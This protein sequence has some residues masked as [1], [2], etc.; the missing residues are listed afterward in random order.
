MTR[1]EIPILCPPREL[2]TASEDAFDALAAPHLEGTAPGLVIDLS[3]V[4][5]ITSAGL[6]R[7]VSLGQ[8]M[9]ARGA[10]VALA[11]GRQSVVKLIRTVGLDSVMPHYP[12][13]TEA[14]EFVQDESR[15]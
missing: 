7:L 15:P 3:E 6:G 4:S 13:V 9:D 2:T 8:R 5:F 1:A 14:V 12:T 10:A 11:G